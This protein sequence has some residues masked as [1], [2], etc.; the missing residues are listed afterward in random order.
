VSAEKKA[1][2]I[3]MPFGMWT[4][5]GPRKHGGAYWRHLAN[6]TEQP[7][8]GGDAAFLS[9]YSDHLLL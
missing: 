2:P 5:V 3:D 4:P 9:H 7:V 6:L 8:C 1:E